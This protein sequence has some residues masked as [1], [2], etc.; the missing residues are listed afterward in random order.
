MASATTYSGQGGGGDDALYG[1]EGN[2]V[3]EGGG[4]ADE[5]MGGGGSDTAAYTM[6]DEAVTIDLRYVDHLTR[7]EAKGGDATGDEFMSIENVR[8]SAEDDMLTGDTAANMLFG[9]QGDD[10]LMGGGGNDTLHGGMDDDVLDGG[11][12]NDKVVG[13]KGD[14]TLTGGEGDDMFVFLEGH[15]DNVITDFSGKDKIFLGSPTVPLPSATVREILRNE[16]KTGDGQYKYAWKDVTF[17]TDVELTNSDFNVRPSNTLTDDPDEWPDDFFTSAT[18]AARAQAGNNEIYGLEGNDKIDG[19]RGNDELYGNSGNDTLMGGSGRDYLDGGRGD[20]KLYGGTGND[21]LMGGTGNDTLAG[22]K[23]NDRLTGGD[24]YDRFVFSK[25]NGSNTVTDFENGMDTIVLNGVASDDED[26]VVEDVLGTVEA[27]GGEYT[28]EWNGTVFTVVADDALTAEDFDSMVAAET[29][30]DD[31]KTPDDDDGKTPD[32]DDGETMGI[33]EYS[34]G[35]YMLGEPTA[36]AKGV[37]WATD[38]EP[39]DNTGEDEIV[40]GTGNDT[41]NGGIRDDS[42]WGG[43]GNDMLNGDDD[44]D[45]L[46][47]GDGDDAL[48]GGEGLDTLWGGE[49][50]DDLDG[51]PGDDLL[52]ADREDTRISGGAGDTD[53]MDTVSLAGQTKGFADLV[54]LGATSINPGN[55]PVIF[56][57]NFIGSEGEDEVSTSTSTGAMIEGRG[58]DDE[59]T[60]GGGSDTIKG[61]DND[62]TIMGLGEADKLYGNDGDDTIDGGDGDDTIDGGA[63]ADELTGGPGNDTFVWGH[64]DTVTDFRESS[65]NDLIDLPAGTSA[66]ELVFT[67]VVADATVGDVMVKLGSES[68]TL[69]GL[70]ADTYAALTDPTADAA[71]LSDYFLF[72]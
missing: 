72:G 36:P 58:G 56:V 39:A 67:K 62:D 57:E 12:G 26:E 33:P 61:G 63:G 22:D 45:L 29:P 18:A 15:G 37:G 32:D 41:I 28:Y 20:D 71:S 9:N 7:P 17:T 5:I 59:L 2:D 43:D 46:V 65:G 1:E 40:G 4:G 42:L 38:T 16:V 49:G 35:A 50:A 52:Y 21:S 30:D 3:L 31:G 48:V 44:H 8:G 64:G 14:D 11:M 53:G 13:D 70:D 66:S 60:G 55:A 54:E 68:M 23:G 6:S 51:G 47:G 19:G 69:E 24:G 25:D 10:M 27:S 34:S